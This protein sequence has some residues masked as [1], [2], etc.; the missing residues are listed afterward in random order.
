MIEHRR[1]VRDPMRPRPIDV[2]F[3]D[4]A[5]QGLLGYLVDRRWQ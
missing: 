5:P 4:D 2:G 1:H 3:G